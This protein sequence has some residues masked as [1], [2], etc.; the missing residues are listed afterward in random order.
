MR[1]YN[2]G[3]AESALASLALLCYEKVERVDF[4][5]KSMIVLV[6]PDPDQGGGLTEC[7]MPCNFA[8][9]PDPSFG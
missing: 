9:I 2:S 5:A 3:T 1:A 8:L 7:D 4:K 6:A